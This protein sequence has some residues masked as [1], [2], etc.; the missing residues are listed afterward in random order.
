MRALLA[1]RVGSWPG[2]IAADH[3]IM[4]FDRKTDTEWL[5]LFLRRSLQIY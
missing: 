2:D 5:R 1:A 3:A 4:A